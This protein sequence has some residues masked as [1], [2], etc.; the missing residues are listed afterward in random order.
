MTRFSHTL[1]KLHSVSSVFPVVYRILSNPKHSSKILA[2]GKKC[3]AGLVILLPSLTKK[4][5]TWAS[6]VCKVVIAGKTFVTLSSKY[7]WFART[8]S[9]DCVALHVHI[10]NCPDLI[11]QTICQKNDKINATI[12]VA[13]HLLYIYIHLE[14]I[15]SL[16]CIGSTNLKLRPRFPF[17]KTLQMNYTLR[18][19]K[20]IFVSRVVSS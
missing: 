18:A 3:N 13:T 11:A 4:K 15:L 7:P 5:L 6:I 12:I 2:C 9:T 20:L 1:H 14:N 8:L 17:L 16:S 10:V 19:P